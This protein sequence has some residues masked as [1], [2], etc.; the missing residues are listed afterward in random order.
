ME[1]RDGQYYCENPGCPQRTQLYRAV[2]GIVPLPSIEE[3][4]ERDRL[5]IN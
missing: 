4:A 1:E 2:V 5:R 3:L